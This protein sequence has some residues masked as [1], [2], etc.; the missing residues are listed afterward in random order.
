MQ[1]QQGLADAQA[2]EESLR[3]ASRLAIV[4]PAL[5][6]HSSILTLRRQVQSSET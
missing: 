1:S 4:Q 5:S 6:T 3:W 2:W